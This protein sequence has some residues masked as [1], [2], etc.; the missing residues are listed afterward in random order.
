MEA[1]ECDLTLTV[2][3][4][5]TIDVAYSLVPVNGHGLLLEAEV[6]LTAPAVATE[7]Q[8]IGQGP[9]AGYPGKDALNEFGRFHLNRGDLDFQGNRRGVELAALVAPAGVGVLLIPETAADV[10]VENSAAGV[11]L[12]PQRRPG[13]PGHQVRRTRHVPESRGYFAHHGAFHPAAAHEKMAG[14]PARLA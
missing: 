1:L 6:A 13:R 12:Q 5:G 11:V 7:F 2:K 8:W 3:P 14:R 4:A 9:Y 10:A